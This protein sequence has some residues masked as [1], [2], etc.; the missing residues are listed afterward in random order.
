MGERKTNLD[1]PVTLGLLLEFTDDFLIPRL[2]DVMSD[3]IKSEVGKSEHRMKIYVDDKLARF[4]A[5]ITGRSE[6]RFEKIDRRF[7][8]MDK[9]FETIEK[10]MEKGFEKVDKRFEKMDKRFENMDKRFDRLEH[11][12]GRDVLFKEKVV[13]VFEE[14]GVCGPDDTAYLRGVI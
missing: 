12:R 8:T 14:R 9:R 3:T 13:D 11:I 4:A 10:R 5:E 1:K 7:E 6:K 2:S